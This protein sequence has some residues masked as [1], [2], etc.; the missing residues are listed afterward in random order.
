MSQNV[1]DAVIS[2]RA[3]T[4]IARL[5]KFMAHQ[6]T[7]E[8]IVA[9][10]EGFAQQRARIDAKIAELQAMRSDRPAVG[11][12]AETAPGPR[13]QFSAA[14]RRKMALAQKARWAKIK[15]E[16]EPRVETPAAPKAKRKMSKEG[17]ARIVAATKARWERVRAEK[18]AAA[19]YLTA[20]T[21]KPGAK[22]TKK[23]QAKKAQSTAS[24]TSSA[25]A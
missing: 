25:A 11:I 22:A 2:V 13:K 17:R 5:V 24:G 10:I 12:A 4:Q 21:K 18:A 15:G 1:V 7:D 6:L 23:A 9:A 20:G 19:K 8:I 3:Q 16:S 14:S